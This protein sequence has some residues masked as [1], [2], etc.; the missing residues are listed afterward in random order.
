M[1]LT[2]GTR[3]EDRAPKSP[4]EIPAPRRAPKSRRGF[5]RFSWLI[6]GVL[7][8]FI[9]FPLLQTLLSVSGFDEEGWQFL[10][11]LDVWTHAETW[12]SLWN[13]LVAVMA[14]GTIAVVVGSVLA[15]IN[16]RTDARIGWAA[17]ILPLVPLFVPAI[18]SAVGWVFLTSPDAGYLNVL[19]RGGLSLIGI[20]LEAGPFN[21]FSWPGLISVYGLFLTPYAYLAVSNGLQSLD[22]SLEEAARISGYGP[23]RA[24][25][26]VVLPNLKPSL[27]AGVVQVLMIG[28]ALFAVPVVIGT[29]A[30]IDVLPVKIVYAMTREYPQDLYGAVGM[31]LALVALIVAANAGLGRMVR[32]GNYATI[33]GRGSRDNVTRL[34]K[35]KV[36]A[37]ILMLGYLSL[38]SLLPFLGVLLVSFQGFWSP[39]FELRTLTLNNYAA[40]LDRPLLRDSVTNSLMLGALAATVAVFCVAIIAYTTSR[41]NNKATSFIDGVIKTPAAV[42]HIVMGL[43]FLVAFGA[44]PFEWT[45]TVWLLV[46]VY[47]V[48]FIPQA[49]LYANSAAQQIGNDMIE[50]AQ[51]SGASPGKIFAKIAV[52]LMGPALISAWALVFVLGWS[53]VNASAML[54]G[55]NNPVVGV[56]VL[57]LFNNGTYPNLAALGVIVAVLSSIVVMTVLS[58][59]RRKR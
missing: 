38:T 31:S 17:E 27:G 45:G 48:I 13:L 49:S 37:R 39:N 36:P 1:T 5:I 42:S 20:D 58:F 11:V 43:A 41:R 54:S 47:V 24:V 21:I 22:P 55:V 9:L 29:S 25:F 35:G 56:Q 33:G 18:V 30:G 50:A 10:R 12:V 4:H 52:P 44:A 34:G 26:K 19:I 46:A 57:D 59:R 51:V 23:Y 14:G 28:S 53:E 6:A 7:T 2:D 3:T 8:F 32:K 40:I 15:W 16:V